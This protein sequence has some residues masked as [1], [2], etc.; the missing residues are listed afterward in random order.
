MNFPGKHFLSLHSYKVSVG[1][2]AGTKIQ[3]P[4]VEDQLGPAR[5]PLSDQV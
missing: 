1:Q 4:R 2:G 3:G 5:V